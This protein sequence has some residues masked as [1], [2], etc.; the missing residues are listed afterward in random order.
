MR[1]TM[2]ARST[3]LLVATVA[4]ASASSYVDRRPADGP[5]ATVWRAAPRQAR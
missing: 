1:I 3:S 4:S 2:S 5:D